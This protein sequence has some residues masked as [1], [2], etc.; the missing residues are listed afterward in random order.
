MSNSL[1]NAVGHS[2]TGQSFEDV[3]SENTTTPAFD[4]A[5]NQPTLTYSASDFWYDG[6]FPDNLSAD[7]T[8]AVST[9]NV[10][11]GRVLEE[12]GLSKT[13]INPG[14]SEGVVRFG[15]VDARP[16]ILKNIRLDGPY[17]QES[18]VSRSQDSDI[19]TVV[20]SGVPEYPAAAVRT[21]TPNGFQVN[22]DG[23]VGGTPISTF[24]DSTSGDPSHAQYGNLNSFEDLSNQEGHRFQ[25]HHPSVS[26][27]YSY[28]DS[29]GPAQHMGTH[30]VDA[31]PNS[32]ATFSET[33]ISYSTQQQAQR[34]PQELSR[35]QQRVSSPAQNNRSYIFEEYGHSNLL[36]YPDALD[37]HA[38]PVETTYP[39]A[40]SNNLRVLPRG[41]FAAIKVTA[42]EAQDK[43]VNLYTSLEEAREF[44]IEHWNPSLIYDNTI[45][46]TTQEHIAIVERIYMALMNVEATDD[47]EQDGK[48]SQA[49][50]NFAVKAKYT[51]GELQALCWELLECCKTRHTH[52]ILVPPYQRQ[53]NK[54]TAEFLT[55]ED[56][57]AQV[58][59]ALQRRKTICKRLL[60]PRYI[61]QVVD[62]PAMHV[63]RAAQNKRLNDNKGRQIQR[64]R[65]NNDK[66][67]G[68]TTG[69]R[70]RPSPEADSDTGQDERG[71]FKR[72]KTNP[73]PSIELSLS[74]GCPVDES[75][76][77]TTTV[78]SKTV[79]P[80]GANHTR[81]VPFDERFLHN[82]DPN[83]GGSSHIGTTS[84]TTATAGTF[85]YN[86]EL[87]TSRFSSDLIE[88]SHGQERRARLSAHHGDL[89][90]DE[91][92][93][94]VSNGRQRR[95]NMTVTATGSDIAHATGMY[96]QD[97][98]M[99]NSAAG[100]MGY[101]HSANYNPLSHLGRLGDTANGIEYQTHQA[102]NARQEFFDPN[103]STVQHLPGC[104]SQSYD[105]SLGAV[106]SYGNSPYPTTRSDQGRQRNDEITSPSN[107][108]R[109][110][111]ATHRRLA[112]GHAS[113][114]KASD[115][116]SYEPP[117]KQRKR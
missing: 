12:T 105:R 76:P 57:V 107:N 42:S 56:R 15:A 87:H 9:E 89:N 94:M 62:N 102:N 11:F 49:W 37:E 86:P 39:A 31:R 30:F 35:H 23:S 65:E 72:L 61:Q 14:A 44:A 55:F 46:R 98:R 17:Q 60:E 63:S 8:S 34:P 13:D 93:D 38:F 112:K 64:G 100:L 5:S 22:N 92:H 6:L 84:T 69:K 80:S 73:T 50:K 75:S 26:L 51:M 53:G 59:V 29:Q 108:D 66:G 16:D 83:L 70:T 10:F 2:N 95:P 117:K 20:N 109:N 116:G 41:E 115:D 74:R 77:S 82:I 3:H 91:N 40:N 18:G 114:R 47:Q 21:V 58:C 104:Q 97:G 111:H 19:V 96:V 90:L 99:I 68:T 48:T 110:L 25:P 78:V 45:P 101:E 81:R 85:G 27:G 103:P 67:K 106:P 1:P 36:S 7:P 54:A 28:T 52:G 113:K 32:Q 79:S 33:P 88:G 71:N 4:L 24:P 43:F